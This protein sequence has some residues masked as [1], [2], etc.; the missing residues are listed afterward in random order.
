M[1]TTTTD[2]MSH[3]VRDILFRI[4]F[5]LLYLN[6]FIQNTRVAV[7]KRLKLYIHIYIDLPLKNILR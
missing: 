2:A 5:L 7:F 3:Y 4:F 1:A 6:V